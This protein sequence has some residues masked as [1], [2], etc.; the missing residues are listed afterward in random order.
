MN[1]KKK[2][3][4]NDVKSVNT[5]QTYFENKNAGNKNPENSLN[6]STI[7][8]NRTSSVLNNDND[9]QATSTRDNYSASESSGDTVSFGSSLG[10]QT[11]SPCSRAPSRTSSRYNHATSHNN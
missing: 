3:P 6:N 2:K 4:E 10:K 7:L 9:S 5:I 1:L 11:T 8:K